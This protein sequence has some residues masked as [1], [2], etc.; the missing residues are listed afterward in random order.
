MPYQRGATGRSANNFLV[1][2]ETFFSNFGEHLLLKHLVEALDRRL[3]ALPRPL[4][5]AAHVD[6]TF[7][8][9][10]LEP[11]TPTVR[12]CGMRSAVLVTYRPVAPRSSSRAE[13]M[14]A[15]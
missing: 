10:Y 12:A 11:E 4:V 3:P 9:I 8:L 6:R 13:T 14:M 2:D 15:R 5:A 1:L 7:A